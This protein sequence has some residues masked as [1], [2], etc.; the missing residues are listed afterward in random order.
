MYQISKNLKINFRILVIYDFED[1]PTLQVI[2]KNF[3][4]LKKSRKVWM[5][6]GETP[7]FIFYIVTHINN[8]IKLFFC[9]FRKSIPT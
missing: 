6:R 9:I 3:E 7:F 5:S 8:F 1:D 4:N 2:K